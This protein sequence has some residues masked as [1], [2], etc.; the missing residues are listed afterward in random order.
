MVMGTTLFRVSVLHC[1]IN[2]ACVCNETRCATHA[3]VVD[4]RHRSGNII[5][6]RVLEYGCVFVS[7]VG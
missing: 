1:L 7:G 2:S 4:F 5:V 6:H 3:H